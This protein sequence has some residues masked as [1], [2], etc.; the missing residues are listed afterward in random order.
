[1]KGGVS[2]KYTDLCKRVLA[3]NSDDSYIVLCFLTG[4]C[5]HNKGCLRGLE[6]GLNTLKTKEVRQ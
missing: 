4:Y 6:A 3:L 2:K 5:K 1:M